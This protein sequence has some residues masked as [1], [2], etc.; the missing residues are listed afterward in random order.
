VAAEDDELGERLA[1]VVGRAGLRLGVAESLTGGQLS[2]RLARAP[3]ASDWFLGGVVAYSRDVKHEVLGVPQ[4]PV[5]SEGAAR[6]MAEGAVRVLGAD[7]AVAVTGA[8][9]P[10]GQDGQPPGT[11]WM[12]LHDRGTTLARLERFRGDPDEVVAATCDVAVRWLVER[13][14]S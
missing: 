8:A 2:A 6:A 5:V 13:C 4:G 11:V 12:A 10:D 3:G 1:E 9:G 14:S 7:V